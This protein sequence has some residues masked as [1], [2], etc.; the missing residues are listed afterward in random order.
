MAANTPFMTPFL[1]QVIHYHTNDSPQVHNSNITTQAKIPLF[2]FEHLTSYTLASYGKTC[3]KQLSAQS[4]II[5][6]NT[7]TCAQK[8]QK[9]KEDKILSGGIT[10]L[11]KRLGELQG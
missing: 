6:F 2:I 7:R 9:R 3:Q 4:A 8:I 5:I 10:Q 11:N 1:F